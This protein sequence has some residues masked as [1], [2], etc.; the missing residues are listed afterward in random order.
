MEQIT[1]LEEF[2]RYVYLNFKLRR[3]VL[4]SVLGLSILPGTLIYFLPSLVRLA[5]AYVFTFF[6]AAMLFSTVQFITGSVV[7]QISI[8][9]Y[10][11]KHKPEER[12]YPEVKQMATK[13]GIK[14][15]KPIYVTNNP[16]VKSPFTNIF[17]G[18]ITLPSFFE[19]KFHQTEVCATIGHELAHIKDKR[20]YAK[21]ML[22]AS[23]VAVAFTFILGLFTIPLICGIA[24]FAFIMLALSQIMWR[25]EYRADKEGANATT[26]EALISVFE[27]L[28]SESKR[29]EGSETHPP[30][31]ARINRLMHLLDSQY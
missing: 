26:P 17:S 13:M 19:K 12:F 10:S 8:S 6:T 22:I 9:L 14:Y 3:T 30:L 7:T 15:E 20:T 16:E 1:R 31:Q 11:R 5:Y 2:L 28:K 23:S 24:E 27:Q 21:E 18:T 4:I 25:N 29:D